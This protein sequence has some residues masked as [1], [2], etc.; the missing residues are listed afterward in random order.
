[1]KL[2]IR[3]ILPSVLCI[4]TFLLVCTFLCLLYTFNLISTHLFEA[5]SLLTGC[6]FYMMLAVGFSKIIKK[7]QLF[8]AFILVAIIFF[9]QLTLHSFSKEL[10]QKSIKL[11]LFI[12]TVIFLKFKHHF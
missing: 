11:F 8:I 7:R 4:L 1:M 9:T 6:I 12:A 10:L 5:A 3:S 2:N